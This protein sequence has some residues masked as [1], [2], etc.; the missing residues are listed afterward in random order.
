MKCV[1]GEYTENKHFPVQSEELKISRKDSWQLALSFPL[2][3]AGWTDGWSVP[4]FAWGESSKP[5]RKSHPQ[6]TRPG[7]N[8]N[9]TVLGNLFYRESCAFLEQAAA[10]VGHLHV[11]TSYNARNCTHPMVEVAMVDRKVL[12][13][14]QD[15]VLTPMV[16]VAMVGGRVPLVLLGGRPARSAVLSGNKLSDWKYWHPQRTSRPL[17]ETDESLDAPS[18][19]ALSVL[20]RA[21]FIRSLPSSSVSL[22]PTDCT[23]ARGRR[24]TALSLDTTTAPLLYEHSRRTPT[25]I[26]I[27]PFNRKAVT[28]FH[29][30]ALTMS[31]ATPRCPRP[32]CPSVSMDS[33]RAHDLC[34]PPRKS[35][36][37]VGR[38]A[39]SK[40]DSLH[41]HW[42]SLENRNKITVMARELTRTCCL[43]REGETFCIQFDTRA[44]AAKHERTARGRLNCNVNISWIAPV[45]DQIGTVALEPREQGA[46]P[47]GISLPLLDTLQ[48]TWVARSSGGKEHVFHGS[49]D[50]NG[51]GKAAASS[52]RSIHLIRV[53]EVSSHFQMRCQVQN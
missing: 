17:L 50:H 24:Q 41:P 20:P 29:G 47:P 39:G 52:Q 42:L 53:H 36:F 32:V 33:P 38:W 34:A 35:K 13:E 15:I 11:L 43:E 44:F 37:G 4:S 25:V 18:P 22:V 16:E 40:D 7:S 31:S 30:T 3:T 14:D 46:L 9:L 27:H 48:I 8:P 1:F 45:V 19:P 23:A 49:N 26:F 51:G 12:L 6:Y 10:E 28:L 21:C 5:I 2:P